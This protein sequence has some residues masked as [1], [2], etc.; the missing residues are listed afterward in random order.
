VAKKVKKEVP[1]QKTKPELDP[2]RKED[3]KRLAA[4]ETLLSPFWSSRSGSSF[5]NSGF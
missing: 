4:L 3:L 1:K 2:Q 5:G